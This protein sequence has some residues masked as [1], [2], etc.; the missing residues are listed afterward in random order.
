MTIAT[1][2]ETKGRWR[3]GG[4]GTAPEAAQLEQSTGIGTLCPVPPGV[5]P[6]GATA[7]RREAAAGV[8][9]SSTGSD[10]AWGHCPVPPRQPG[11]REV[12]RATFP[13][14][15]D[16]PPHICAVGRGDVTYQYTPVHQNLHILPALPLC[17][18]LPVHTTELVLDTHFC[19]SVCMLLQIY[20]G[21]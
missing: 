12:A 11:G 17:Y 4:S 16:A 2:V 13:R 1:R 8:S 7:M 15:T 14:E 10:R 21:T 20:R 18:L 5:V 19:G 3:G 6:S 9:S